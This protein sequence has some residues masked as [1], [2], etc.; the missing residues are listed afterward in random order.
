MDG[1]EDR[2]MRKIGVV[3]LLLLPVWLHAEHVFEMGLHGGVAGWNGKTEYVDRRVGAQGGAHVYYDYFSSHVIGFRL[4]VTIDMHNASF[5]KTNYEDAYSTIDVENEQMDVIYSINDLNE[6]YTTYSV[7]IPLQIALT[8]KGF[9]FLAGAKAV[10]PLAN[11]WKQSVRH[12]ALAVYYPDYDNIVEESFPLAASRDFEM[13]QTGRLT[14]P[15][16][17]WWAAIEAG[18]AIPINN[19]ATSYRSYIMVGAYFDY[20]FSKHKAAQSEA[21]SLIML[22]DTRDGFPLQRLLTPVMEANRQG[23]KL[24]REATLF[25]VGIKISYAISPYDRASRR[26]AYRC[27]CLPF[28][29]SL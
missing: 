25:D 18:Y 27:Q 1:E 8:A 7:G 9:H 26:R 10:F 11:S 23:R 17:Q 14:L 16:V 4:G 12:A 13:T 19:W 6:R 3:I 2:A 21:E 20:C 28:T 15:T 29:Y 22:S 24:V 5:G